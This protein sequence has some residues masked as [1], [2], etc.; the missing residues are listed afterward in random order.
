MYP[1]YPYVPAR[2]QGGRRSHTQF[3]VV[4]TME[5]PKS[6]RR[7]EDTAHYFASG[8]TIGSAHFCVDNNS[9]VQC[10]DERNT[11]NHAAGANAISVGIEHAGYASQSAPE[12]SDGYNIGM[13]RDHS[14][15]L[16]RKILHQFDLP[17]RYVQ[18]KDLRQGAKGW[19]THWQVTVAFRGSRGHWDPGPNFPFAQYQVWIGGAAPP[20]PEPP[21][22]VP[23]PLE[24]PD[25]Y[26][27]SL[28]DGTHDTGYSV[29]NNK[30][31]F[32]PVSSS[33]DYLRIVQAGAFTPRDKDGHPVKYKAADIKALAKALHATM[34][35]ANG[36]IAQKP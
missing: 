10:V 21:K 33:A 18:A 3:A 35:N 6:P 1:E 13:L 34:F 32:W 25:M 20:K 28:T 11:A 31:E 22:P 4:H 19:T 36:S 29:L 9:V 23:I 7:A 16:M 15:P 12:W 24:V 26:V 8:S 17:N 30:N 5:A 14:A 2:H 27:Y